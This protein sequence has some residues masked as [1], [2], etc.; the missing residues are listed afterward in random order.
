[1][2]DTES[3]IRGE[4]T[5]DGDAVQAEALEAE[6]VQADGDLI[7]SQDV[8]RGLGHDG[9][10]PRPSSRLLRDRRFL[11]LWGAQVVSN[12]G[13]WAFVL[14]VAAALTAR[15]DGADLARAMALVAA[16]A[17]GP[18]ALAGLLVAGSIADRFDRRRVMVVAD[19]I[20]AGAVA[21]LLLVPDPGILHV[22]LVA[23]CLGLCQS[24]F[25]PSLMASLPH[26]VGKDQLVHANAVTTGTYHLSIMVGPAVGAILVAT[27]GP[28]SAFALNALSF[29]VS[30]ALLARIPLGRAERAEAD[31]WEPVRDLVEGAR[32]IVRTP[33]TRGIAVVMGLALMLVA[34]KGPIEILVVR[35]RVT[36][37]S[38]GA[39]ARALGVL[40]AAWG[41]GMVLGSLLAPAATAHASRERLL[42]AAAMVT[43]GCFLAANQLRSVL[44]VAALWLVA[45]AATGV[46]NVAYET[47]LQ[48]RTPDGLR[49]RAFATTEAVQD[50]MY[51]AGALAIAA[52]GVGGSF[53]PLGVAFVGVGLVTL[54]LLVPPA[55]TEPTAVRE[56]APAD[57]PALEL[58]A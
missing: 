47:L 4:V 28:A 22:A 35:D 45:G 43:G 49:G 23:V 1:V 8:T 36:D 2:S 33:L 32:Y 10:A 6:A 50:L 51:L 12:V 57:A 44:P 53:A 39:V 29:V 13:D 27:A 11:R 56:P 52:I 3:V 55:A 46:A 54:G 14:A 19:L 5:E 31:G 18:S 15:L 16:S 17:V 42:A 37:G 30:A 40:T 34:A 26:V 7:G 48:E 41:S 38:L 9:R 25:Q 58:A 24:V 20:R 21:T